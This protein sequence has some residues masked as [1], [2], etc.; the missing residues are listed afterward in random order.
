MFYGEFDYKIDEKGR[1]PIPPKFRGVF[2]DGIVLTSSAENCITAYTVT[3]WKKLS[4]SLTN[5]PLSRSKM[6]RLSRV[7]FSTAFTTLIDGQGRIAIP[8]PLREHAQIT[9]DA[10]VV[11]VN[12]YLELWNKALWE[13]EK[14]VSQ[15]QAWQI[16]ESLE[17]NE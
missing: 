12:T 5:S 14:A 15:Q 1:L 11:G 10:V 17:T 2:K 16:I 4:A 8:A 13:E 3:E 6:R 9:G 7:L